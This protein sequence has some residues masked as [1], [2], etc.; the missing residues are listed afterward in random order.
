MAAET[1]RIA[2]LLE[3]TFDKQPWYGSS[4]MAIL[5]EVDSSLVHKRLGKAHT[6]IELVLHMTAWRT[7]VIKRLSGD[8]EFQVTD[9]LNFP[10][11]STPPD[12][13]KKAIKSLQDNQLELLGLINKLPDE[14][15]GELVPGASHKYTWYTLLHGI[16]DHDV[17]HLGQI[18]ILQKALQGV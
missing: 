2:R 12:A 18:A 8:N 5:S 3:K 15:L 6:M 7:F 11:P 4:V 16:I 13:W 10:K 14:K 17:Y 9:A 1:D